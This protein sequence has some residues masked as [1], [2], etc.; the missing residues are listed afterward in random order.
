M[1]S[2]W[3]KIGA[4]EFMLNV[5]KQKIPTTVRTLNKTLNLKKKFKNK[6]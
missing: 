2:K 3:E 5:K 4:L 6:F 1:L